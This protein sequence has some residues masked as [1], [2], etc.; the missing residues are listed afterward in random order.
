MVAGACSKGPGNRAKKIPRDSDAQAVVYIDSPDQTKIT[1]SAEAEPNNQPEEASPLALGSGV[2]GALDGQD[3]K[4]LYQ[5]IIERPGQL[6]AQL[7]GIDGVDL[8]LE[9]LDP[10]GKVLAI[11]DRGP[12]RSSEGL[13]NIAVVAGTHHLRVGEFVKKQPAKKKRKRKKKKKKKVEE[14]VGRTGLSPTYELVVEHRA[15]AED[16]HE[17]E[18]NDTREQATEIL[19]GDE[20]FGF[21]G[22]ARDVDVWKLSTE[23]F[24][25]DYGVDLELSGVP[26]VTFKLQIL[27]ENGKKILQRRA[28]KGGGL[29]LR[30]LMVVRPEDDD[31]PVPESENSDEAEPFYYARLS[32]RRS[33]PVDKYR[34]RMSTRLMEPDEEREPNDAADQ[35]MS[36]ADITSESTGTLR[37]YLMHGDTDR[38]LIGPAPEATMVSVRVTPNSDIDVELSVMAGGK[39]LASSNASKRGGVESASELSLAAGATAMIVVAGHGAQAGEAGYELRWSVEPAAGP[40]PMTDDDPAGGL[41]DYEDTP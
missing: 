23:G 33:N 37:G 4:D 18:G 25:A 40:P 21:I 17:R 8:T 6:S 11:S 28:S 30:N 9:L 3:D 22:W 26:G 39:T 41:D 35:A 5:I 16:R 34:L 29:S 10:E 7:S 24:A 32:A 31:V 2:R 15:N 13:P 19:L 36:L 27:D 14:P 20:A 1:F 12:A 38:Y